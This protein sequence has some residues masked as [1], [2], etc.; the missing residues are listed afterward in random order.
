[1]SLA[2][3]SDEVIRALLENL[4][5]EEAENFQDVLKNA[6]HEY[7]TGTQAAG[8]NQPARTSTYS[9]RTGTTTMFMPSCSPAGNGIKVVT[10]SSPHADPSL[11]AIRP[12]GSLTLYSPEGNPVGFLHAQTLTA[13][14]TALA[15]SCLLT[16]RATVRTLTVFGSGLQAYWHIRL[17]LLLR[18]STIRTVNIINR[19]FSDN[20]RNIL[21]KFYAVPL[22]VKERE[23]WDQA[24]FSVLTPG[25]GEYDRL[26]KEHVREADVIYCCTPSTTELF[27]AEILTSREGRRKGRLVVAIGSYSEDMR[28]LPR[29]LL[30][31][32]TR[33][34]QHGHLHYHK[35]AT[36]G[37]VII[38]DSLDGALKEAG[39]LI[40]AGLGPKQ[41]VE[42]GELIMIRRLAIED[43][44]TSSQQSAETDSVSEPF[45]KLDIDS[46]T[47][48]SSSKRSSSRS[49]SRASSGTGESGSSGF[50]LPAILNP[51]QHHKRSK[52]HADEKRNDHLARWLTAGNVIYK[53]VGL[54]LMDLVIGFQI[55]KLANEKGV[56]GHLQ[57]FSPTSG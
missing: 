51:H 20:A 39:E 42:L 21:K 54:G 27:N 53:S 41:L 18:G 3:L 15:S 56:G 33:T 8:T 48:N 45:D 44:D 29:D 46:G 47:M 4:T 9:E 52:S 19:R 37:G 17:A 12:T 50:H 5:R 40:D 11:P 38:V 35:H 30:A 26:Q 55:I 13:F 57:D 10:V 43:S 31:Q 23:G 28:E 1:M 22:E 6:L 7:S 2:I 49:P 24:Q 16:K 14:R 34:H 25:Y 36:E 32:A